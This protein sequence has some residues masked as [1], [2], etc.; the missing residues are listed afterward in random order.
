MA[1]NRKSGD[2]NR[3]PSPKNTSEPKNESK[4]PV[5]ETETRPAATEYTELVLLVHASNIAEGELIKTELESNGIPAILEGGGAGVAG[6]PDVGSGVPVL[7]PEEYADQAAELIAELEFARPEGNT[8]VE[9]NDL[10]EEDE[11]AEELEE[12]DEVEENVKDEDLDD[13]EE[14]EDLDD[15]E[16]DDL[17]DDDE[18]EADEDDEDLEDD[19]DDWDDD[20]DDEDDDD[21]Y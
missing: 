4:P 5:R 17:D 1:R 19:E 10:F 21:D 11:G 9:K 6:I 18:E 12:V 3:R 16:D 13:D 8:L 2:A 14:D 15:D 7:V 20:E